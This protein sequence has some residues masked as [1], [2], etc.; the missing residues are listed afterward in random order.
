MHSL[1][2]PT[3]RSG[4]GTLEHACECRRFLSNFS[5]NSEQLAY[6]YYRWEKRMSYTGP[7]RETSRINTSNMDF[8][9][10]NTIEDAIADLP[11]NSM[12][13]VF[14]QDV[15]DATRRGADVTALVHDAEYSPN[16]VAAF[17]G[18]SRPH[19]LGFLNSGDLASH[20]VGSHRR[21][22]HSDFV[23]FKQ[24]RENA[25][26][27]VASAVARESVLA[28]TVELDVDVMS[29]LDNL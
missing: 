25:A 27:V 29:D 26:K 1:S 9:E 8:S 23:D 2:L 6:S 20:Y 7:R 16:Q 17:L 21:I 15:I 24:R 11:E 3:A 19:L 18:I 4:A 14:I 12:L 22:S 5:A 10:V 13:R 28:T